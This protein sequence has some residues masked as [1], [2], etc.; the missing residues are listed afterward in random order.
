MIYSNNRK[1]ALSGWL[2]ANSEKEYGTPLKLQKFLLFYESFAKANGEEPDFGHLRGWKNGPVFSNVW[3]DYTKERSLFNDTAAQ[4]YEAFG[5]SINASRAQK[6]A[7]LVKTLSESELSELTHKMNLWKS[8]KGRILS[9]EYQVDLHEED[10]T[11]EDVNI[12]N[13]LDKM[14]TTEVVNSSEVIEIDNHYFIFSKEDATQLKEQHFDILAKLPE[15]DELHN[16][17]YVEI[18]EDGR[19]VID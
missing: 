5:E 10:F 2:K 16:P 15:V 19:L 11:D 4:K 13:A 17:V 18:D 6:C 3:G 9:G 7:F 1:L 8:K 12:I 14:Y